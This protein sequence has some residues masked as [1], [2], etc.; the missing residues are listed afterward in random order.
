MTVEASGLPKD[1]Y[2]FV[3]E[4]FSILNHSTGSVS[5]DLADFANKQ[6]FLIAENHGVPALQQAHVRLVN[7][8]ARGSS[9][10]T[11]EGLRPGCRIRNLTGSYYKDFPPSLHVIGSDCRGF[12]DGELYR[13]F[14]NAQHDLALARLNCVKFV[15]RKSSK[16]AEFLNAQMEL[17]NVEVVEGAI[18]VN[19]R[20]FVGL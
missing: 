20:I 4:N 16:I 11:A 10:I 14:T 9:C 15:Q 7:Y 19:H 17:N 8:M 6:L 2:D 1:Q 13:Q 18:N 5:K 12:P 3:V